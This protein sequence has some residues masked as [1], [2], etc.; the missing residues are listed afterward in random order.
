MRL[1]GLLLLSAALLGAAFGHRSA[2]GD[3]DALFQTSTI[4]ALMAGVYDGQMTFRELEQHG[5]FGL[6]TVNGLDGEMVGLDGR[7]YQIRSDGVVSRIDGAAKTPFAVVKRFRADRTI[8]LSEPADQTRLGQLLDRM[9]PTKNVCYA[10]RIEGR[11]RSMTARSVARQNRPYPPLAEATK[12]QRIFQFGEVQGTIVGFRTPEW[13]A[14]VNVP[15]YHFHFVTADR[16]AG[17]HVLACEVAQ[18]TIALDEARDFRV[19]LPDN[20]EFN[21]A[22]LAPP[23]AEVLKNVEG[24]HGR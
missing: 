15:G 22:D 11:F 13:M 6:G 21:Q 5:D 24:A 14:G 7:F 16:K 17:G 10:I 8:T 3:E 20:A 23:A 2:G 1:I 9:L 18:A 19:A 12:G 4:S